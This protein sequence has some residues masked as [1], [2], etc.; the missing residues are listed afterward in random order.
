MSG[1]IQTP[2]FTSSFGKSDDNSV[3][4]SDYVV[5]TDNS[6][7]LDS[8]SFDVDS[9]FDEDISSDSNSEQYSSTDSIEYAEPRPVYDDISTDS[10]GEYDNTDT[11]VVDI[12]SISN[13]STYDQL[14]ELQGLLSNKI[15]ELS[16]EVS[17]LED[18]YNT[19]L[20][21]IQNPI[22]F[23]Q[24]FNDNNRKKASEIKEK[25]DPL[26]EELMTLLALQKQL[27]HAIELAPYTDIA[28]TDD[29]KNFVDNYSCEYQG[30]DYELLRFCN[31]DIA[32]YI[33]Q[34]TRKYSVEEL[35]EMRANEIDEFALIEYVLQN[36]PDD[37]DADYAISMCPFL[38]DAYEKYKYMTEEEIMMYHYLYSTEGKES[39]EKYFSIIEDDVNQAIGAARAFEFINGLDLTDEGKL[40][41]SLKNLFGV[42][43]KGLTDGIGNFFD[44]LENIF[45]NDGKLTASDYEKMIILQ[46]LQ[47]NSVYHDEI[48]EFSSSFGN[49]VPAIVASAIVTFIATPAGGAT[50]AGVSLSASQLGSI[51]AST[52]IG[53]S[54]MGNAKH[55]ALVNG[56]DVLSSTLYG[57]F[58][59]LSE[60]TLGYFLGNIPGISKTAGFTLRE[61]LQE[62]VEEYLQ[63]WIDA[64]LQAVILGQ[65]I[66]LSQIPE[67]ATKSFVMGVLMSAFLNGGQKAVSLVIDGTNYTVNVEDILEYMNTHEDA[68]IMTAL[69][70]A[71][72]G[73][74]SRLSNRTDVK[75]SLS[76]NDVYNELQ[77]VTGGE[78]SKIPNAIK[79]LLS[80]YSQNGRNNANLRQICRTSID[81]L[82]SHGCTAEAAANIVSHLY[83]DILMNIGFVS[84]VDPDTGIRLNVLKGIDWN[85]QGFNINEVL[86]QLK[87]LPE[88]FRSLIKEVNF[89]DTF[90]P[91]DFYW[92][93]EYNSYDFHSAATGGGGQINF[94]ATNRFDLST[95]PHEMG[96]SADTAWASSWG[97]ETSRISDSNLWKQAMQSDLKTSGLT[98]VTEYART[99]YNG[100]GTLHEDFAES[101][102]LFYTNPNALDAFPARKALLMK[103]LPQNETIGTTY[104]Q[105][106]DILVN[107]YG[108]EETQWRLKKYYETG[109]DSYITRDGGARDMLKKYTLQEF[110]TYMDQVEAIKVNDKY[111]AIENSFYLCFNSLV[112]KYGYKQAIANLQ[113]YIDTGDINRITRYNGARNSIVYSIEDYRDYVRTI[114]NGSLNVKNIFPGN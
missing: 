13:I 89:Y 34:L 48:Y 44:G 86:K 20:I 102:A 70:Y 71:E 92:E 26:K 35:T 58:I 9:Y 42:G 40:E 65:D 83:K 106:Y 68:D 63:E 1:S 93:L 23:M 101:I 96:H 24:D 95:I 104:D 111:R 39:A 45:K 62:G 47:Q 3:N 67:N 36:K 60:T 64:G 78:N 15:D 55:Q 4:T 28:D 2:N 109:Q 66:D 38:H 98:G 99:A 29:Y 27:N 8:E 107:K 80:D 110:R 72:P 84:K 25:L 112:Q 56:S 87:S 82:K 73:F 19:C 10:S 43:G 51:A 113:S 105:V 69:E 88:E 61:I 50:V 30:L 37:V 57:L 31:F 54:A 79:K 53:L 33:G 85:N 75:N 90:N 77:K 97:V 22:P 52:L 21:N 91:A 100:N 49:M 114:N 103:Y 6:I 32:M 12:S 108:E 17:S 18:E 16:K 74:F 46:Y 76:Y 59:G 5:S 41:D 94:W 11:G 14:V 7:N 81:Y